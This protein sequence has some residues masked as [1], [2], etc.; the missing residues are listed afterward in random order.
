MKKSSLL[1]LMTAFATLSF[2]ACSGGETTTGGSSRCVPGEQIVCACPGT[3][4]TG[5]QVCNALGTGYEACEGCPGGSGSG[6]GGATSAAT[7]GK[8]GGTTAASG[9]ATTTASS[10]TG[11]M[12]CDSGDCD[13]CI[14]STCAEQVCAT[15][16]AACQDDTDCVALVA[17]MANCPN[18]DI[19]CYVNCDNAHPTG[20]MLYGV[21]DYCKHCTAC[22]VDCMSICR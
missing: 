13:V 11:G 19:E 8:G 15:E 17:C 2:W 21:A 12:A 22:S 10:A 18:G 20:S 6:S 1:G 3:S 5:A 16:I 9:P 4:V 7:A 14:L